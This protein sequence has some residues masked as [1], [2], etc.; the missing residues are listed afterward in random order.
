MKVA[1]VFNF[2]PAAS[3]PTYCSGFTTDDPAHTI[4][5]I[6]PRYNNTTVVSVNA[7]VYRGPA[8]WVAVRSIRNPN[9]W[10]TAADGSSIRATIAEEHWTTRVNSGGAHYAT[11]AAICL[12]VIDCVVCVAPVGY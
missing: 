12:N 11:L 5:F 3:C 1:P 7:V 9:C 6:N 8:A 4:D 2:G 10:L